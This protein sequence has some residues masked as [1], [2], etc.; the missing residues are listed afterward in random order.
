MGTLESG[1]CTSSLPI[2]LNNW[3]VR[4]YFGQ[5]MAIASNSNVQSQ[6]NR[7]KI[8]CYVCAGFYD[9]SWLGQII[10]HTHTHTHTHTRIYTHYT[11]PLVNQ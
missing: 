6:V 8:T 1:T 2:T 5:N 3:K 9:T 7:K 11:Y 4:F 10:T